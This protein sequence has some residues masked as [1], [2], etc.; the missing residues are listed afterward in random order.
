MAYPLSDGAANPSPLDP[1]FNPKS[2]AIIGA[3]ANPIKPSGQPLIAL[4]NNGYA[5]EVYPVNPKYDELLG[6]KCYPRISDIPGPVDMAIIAVPAAI[7]MLALEECAVKGVKVAVIF[8]SGFAEVGQEGATVQQQMAALAK[9][10]GMRIVGPNCMGLVNN[11]NNLMATFFLLKLPTAP[12]IPNVLGFVSQSGGFG[13]L[14]YFLVEE[15]GLGFTYY[16]SSGNEADLDFSDYLA[17]MAPDPNVRVLGGYLEG[18]RDGRK[19]MAAADLALAHEKPIMI[20]KAG[21][22]PSAARAAASHTGAMVGSDRVYD[23]FF[24]QKNI[25]RTESID[26]MLIAINI[27]ACGR[28]PKGPRVGIISAS[29]GGGV[30]LADKCE[31][32]GL[33]VTGL[34]AGTRRALDAILPPFASSANPVDITSQFMVQQGLL[35]EAAK[36][37]INDPN[38]DTLMLFCR[39]SSVDQGNSSL[40]DEVVHLY[41]QTDKPMI[42]ITWGEDEEARETVRMLREHRIPAVRTSDYAVYALADVVQWAKRMAE[43]KAR[44]KEEKPVGNSARLQVERL[45]AAYP[46]KAQLT[47]SQSKEILKAYGIPVTREELATTPEEAALAATRLGFPVVMKIDSPDIL[48]KTDAGGVRLGIRSPEEAKQAFT[49]IV[50]NARNYKPD[51]NIRGVLVQEMLTGATEVIVG[52]SRDPV[53]GPVVMFGLGGILVEVLEDVCLRVAPLT[54]AEAAEMLEE[55]RGKKVLD[56]V[57]GRPPVDKEAIIDVIVRLSHLVADFPDIAEMD[58]NPLLVFPQG[59]GAKA[60]DALIVKA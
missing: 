6:V 49:E 39:L 8:T 4:L 56:G 54:R 44:P 57:R 41:E 11:L 10:S 51:A 36:Q 7:T 46:A 19:L 3:S 22:N 58:I 27:I 31:S 30:V 48:H 60:A 52:M 32:T 59:Q 29:G 50:T 13:S 45:L 42:A 14:I 40:V 24:R 28:I 34:T 53:F 25:I 55:I 9:R 26:E 5:G 2:V 33:Q 43:F 21:R 18:V 47:E 20:L 15:A 35:L 1:V 12:V 37:V 17:Y 16:V 38:V 23:A